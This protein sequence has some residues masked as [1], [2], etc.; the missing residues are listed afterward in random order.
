MPRL[1]EGGEEGAATTLPSL[2]FRADS[3]DVEVAF[4][5]SK[6][7]CGINALKT[8]AD[9]AAELAGAGKPGKP[10]DHAAF[11]LINGAYAVWTKTLKREFRVLWCD[12]GDWLTPAARFCLEVAHR[13]DP[14]IELS[15]IRTAA[16]S[17]REENQQK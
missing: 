16:R 8:C 10:P 5:F 3:S 4:D 1:S 7:G 15:R 14:A 6:W 2:H 11:F 13:V 9:R 12:D 17:V